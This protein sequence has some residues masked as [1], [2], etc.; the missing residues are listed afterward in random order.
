VDAA[1]QHDAFLG[2]GE[3]EGQRGSQRRAVQGAQQAGE[4]VLCQL[5]VGS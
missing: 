2:V 3:L 1:G 5:S 4:L